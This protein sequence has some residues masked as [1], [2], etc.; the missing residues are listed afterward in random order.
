ML[1]LGTDVV[2]LPRSVALYTPK[3][4][5][6]RHGKKIGSHYKQVITYGFDQFQTYIGPGTV[7]AGKAK[8]IS[9][10]TNNI[11]TPLLQTAARTA[12]ST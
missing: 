11:L 12:S 1:G 8:P 6:S 7:P 9:F 10:T 3:G 5:E 2:L 4:L